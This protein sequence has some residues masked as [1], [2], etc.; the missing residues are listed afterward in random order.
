MLFKTNLIEI[1]LLLVV[2]FSF[3]WIGVH[4]QMVVS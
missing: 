1:L 2:I 3:A 4:K